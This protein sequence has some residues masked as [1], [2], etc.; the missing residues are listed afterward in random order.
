MR[1]LDEPI[2][3]PNVYTNAHFRIEPCVGCP[4]AGYLIVSPRAP[5]SSLSQLSSDAQ[6]SLGNTLAAA[7]GAIEAVIGPDRIYCLLFAEE[8][9]SIHFHLFPRSAWLLSQYAATH[10]TDHDISGPRL[11]DWAR[12]TFHHPISSEYSETVQA[13]FR[14]LHSNS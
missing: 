4:I 11:L 10:P 5:V 13:I 7:T 12:R 6:S 3:E 8:T 9:P 2:A 14:E 1:A